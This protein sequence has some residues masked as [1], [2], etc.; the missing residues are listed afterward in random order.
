M[1]KYDFII[2]GAGLFGAV[3]AHEMT[4]L[5]RHCLVIDKKPHVGGLCYTENIS[6]IEVHKYGPH[7]F[8]CDDSYI[9][10]YL[11]RFTSFNNYIN[12]PKVYYKGKFYSFPINLKTM[13][14]LWGIT[15]LEEAKIKLESIRIKNNNPQNCEEWI[16]SQVGR[17]IYEIFFKEYTK[18]QWGRD[19][20]DLPAFIVKRIPI[21][22]TYD[23]RYYSNKFQ[24]IPT[25]GYTKMIENMLSKIE[26]R[27]K[28]DFFKNR[29]SLE[30]LT[31]NIIFTGRIDQYFNHCF[32]KLEYRTM[33]FKHKILKK[34][35]QNSAII[36]Y[37]E[38]SIPFV[39]TVEHKHFTS[40]IHKNTV[41]TW[42]YPCEYT[43]GKEP[44]YPINNNKNQQLYNKYYKKA[45]ML[46]NVFFGGRLGEY[47]YYDMHQTIRSA[48]NLSKKLGSI[49]E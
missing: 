49:N 19:P 10:N 20:K 31:H 27:L 7:I 32:G 28:T 40:H 29:K 5:G 6:G 34:T 23:D 48:L 8:H 30:S 17:E 37:T 41:V 15:T 21:H 3:F 9:Y 39:R 11:L 1:K 33:Q 45:Q 36:N 24:G 43:E 47:K 18:K 22:L 16:T 4:N 25:N 38:S 42:E 26:T 2:V 14:Q 35:F 44:C 12:R 13:Q 46:K